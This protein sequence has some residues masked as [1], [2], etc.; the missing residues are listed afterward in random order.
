MCMMAGVGGAVRGLSQSTS[1]YTQSDC[2]RRFRVPM[3][4]STPAVCA[5]SHDSGSGDMHRDILQSIKAPD[6]TQA[7]LFFCAMLQICFPEH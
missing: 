5:A 4:E 7:L 2:R 3:N 6:G 1:I